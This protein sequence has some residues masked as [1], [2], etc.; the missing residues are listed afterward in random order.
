MKQIK[1]KTISTNNMEQAFVASSTLKRN[2]RYF[3]IERVN[4]IENDHQIKRRKPYSASQDVDKKITRSFLSSTAV[5]TDRLDQDIG[6]FKNRI[7]R[8][9]E[10]AESQ[11]VCRSARS[12]RSAKS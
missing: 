11:S 3:D 10:T 2:K 1:N 7:S 4:E 6:K 8:L 12:S 9:D 5:L